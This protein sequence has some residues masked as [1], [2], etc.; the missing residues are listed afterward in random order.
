MPMLEIAKEGLLG[1]VSK[2][3][4]L[5]LFYLIKN[6]SWVSLRFGILAVAGWLLSLAFV[7]LGTK[8]LLG[9]YQYILSLV[10]MASIFSL[11]GLNV[12]ALEAIVKGRETGIFRAVKLSFLLSL[13][14]VPILVG[15]G[16]FN[17]FFEGNILIGKALIIAGLLVP[18]YYALNTW[19]VYYDAKCLF[20]EGSLRIIF[21]NI[22]LNSFLI[23]GLILKL[24]VLGLIIIYLTVNILFFGYYFLEVA[25]KIKNRAKDFIDITFS[26]KVSVQ[27]FVLGLSG[28][29][30]PIAISYLFGI[31]FVAIYFIA[32]YFIS[33]ITAFLGAFTTLYIPKLFKGLKLNHKNIMFQNMFAGVILWVF[34]VLFLKVFFI[35]IYGSGYQKSLEIAY[36]I[37][38]LLLLIPLKTYFYGFFM[39]QKRN[40]LLIN[41]ALIANLA[42]LIFLYL[43]K[44]ENF[45]FA[46]STYL[47]V[48][49]ILTLAPLLVIY[50]G[51]QIEKFMF[52][53]N[54]K[55]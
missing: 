23:L 21:I 51:P 54:L 48:L 32:Y 33:A 22:F 47:Y 34:F 14:A 20:K 42:A 25:K 8:E 28:N 40:Y 5:N 2:K 50:V 19:N 46:I 36:R 1:K 17:W 45:S 7:R 15:I 29:I 39:T 10:S 41:T 27:K 9:Q 38:F 26:I 43:A 37:S 11:P 53:N 12:S 49:E 13:L 16:F 3:V 44:S 4:G 24:N 30:P 18:L 35:P 55:K 31:E 52:Y 6:G